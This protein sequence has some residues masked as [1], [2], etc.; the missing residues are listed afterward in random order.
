MPSKK[1]EHGKRKST[2]KECGGSSI[3]QHLKVR[4][5]CKECGGGSICPHNRQKYRCKECLAD[6]DNTIPEVEEYTKEE[7]EIISF[8]VKK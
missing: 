3:C 7:Y 5:Q 4:S 6:K 2:C 1:C 8:L